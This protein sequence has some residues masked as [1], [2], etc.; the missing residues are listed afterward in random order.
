[1]SEA[2]GTRENKRWAQTFYEECM[3]RSGCLTSIDSGFYRFQNA[4]L[5]SK[6]KKWSP[7]K[8][9]VS[10]LGY[11]ITEKGVE[12]DP[13]NVKCK[14][15]PIWVTNAVSYYRRFVKE[16]AATANS[17]HSLT[18]KDKYRVWN[19]FS[20]SE[21][22]DCYFTYSCIARLLKTI[23]LRYGH[24]W[25]CYWRSAKSN[26]VK[27]VISYGSRFLLKSERK[28]SITRKELSAV[29][30]IVA[31]FGYS[32]LFH[33]MGRSYFTSGHRGP[34]DSESLHRQLSYQIRRTQNFA[35]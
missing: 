26:C 9:K 10:Y 15:Q 29:C 18:Q 23:L 17:L 12:T 13:Q 28:Y 20:R 21:K 11:V 8:Y 14:H 25:K 2:S 30:S 5:R 34:D 3:V 7:F 19:S 22:N 1:M 16:F 6:S 24:I 31:Q 4:E 35:Y 32:R 33:Q 27:Q